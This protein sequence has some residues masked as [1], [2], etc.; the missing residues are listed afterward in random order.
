MVWV[1][2]DRLAI[3]VIFNLEDKETYRCYTKQR[4]TCNIISFL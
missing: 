4:N 3:F 1:S 2:F